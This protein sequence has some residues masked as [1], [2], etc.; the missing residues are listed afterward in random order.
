MRAPLLALLLVAPLLAGCATDGGETTALVAYPRA[1]DVATY[2]AEGAMVDLARWENGHPLVGRTAIEWTVGGNVKALDGARAVH[3]AY[4]VT[5]KVGGVEHA[6]LF[7]ARAPQAVVQSYYKLSQDQGV[8]A[9]DERGFPWLWGASALF[10]E[11]LKEGALVP[12]SLPDNLGGARSADL[13]WRVGARDADGA[14]RI[15]LEGNASVDATLWMEEGSAW[16]LR[17]E[18]TLK[19]SGLAPLV[20]VDGPAPASLTARRVDV[21]PGGEPVPPRDRGSTFGTDP[22]VKRLA[23]DGEKPP[24]GAPGYVPYLLQDAV[25][26]AKLVDAP[27]QAW[28]QA[29]KDPR[30]YRATHKEVPIANDTGPVASPRSPY[31]LVQF[32]DQDERYYEVQVERVDVGP[33]GQGVPRVTKSGPAVAPADE[34][35]GW[36]AKDAAPGEIVPLAE[37]VRVVREVF[38]ATRIEIFLRSFLDPVGYSYYIDGGFE[39]GGTGRYTVV[40][41]PA[42]GFIEG[43]TGPVAPRL[44]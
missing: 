10:G 26:D 23:W 11:E 28:L 20:R 34:N 29:A 19:D 41:N 9:F 14:W 27:L 36:F 44:A 43:S 25:R 22:T 38:G 32:V 1:G 18:M 7:V 39:A 4:E 6:R 17:V 15:V 2:E 40:Y 12:F 16:P 24:D 3:D 33:L 31:W 8:L 21:R 35:H 42:T 13:A 5:R 30:V 37:G